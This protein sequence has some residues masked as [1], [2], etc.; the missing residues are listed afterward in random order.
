MARCCD[1][2]PNFLIHPP[3]HDAER[4]AWPVIACA[5][6]YA[7]RPPPER[8][9]RD[10]R[11]CIG[12]RTSARAELVAAVLQG[13]PIDRM[14]ALRRL[15]VGVDGERCPGVIVALWPGEC[16]GCGRS[17][18]RRADE[19]RRAA[20]AIQPGAIEQLLLADPSLRQLRDLD[21]PE[22]RRYQIGHPRV[23][24]PGLPVRATARETEA[25]QELWA[26]DLQARASEPYRAPRR[27][28]KITRAAAQDGNR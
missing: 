20:L 4:P 18:L 2:D 21:L 27:R 14:V 12:A 10:G 26:L 16:P 15:L 8:G 9:E 7:W 11:G 28:T 25:A 5:D 1:M 23:E 13:R 22:G 24:R 6:G 19:F 17:H 3:T